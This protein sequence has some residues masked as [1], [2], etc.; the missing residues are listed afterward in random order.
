MSDPAAVTYF[1]PAKVNL[2]LSVRDLRS[3]GYHELHSLMV[4][5]SVGDDL[6]IAPADTL[7]LRVEGADL[8]IDEGN[9]VF[10]AARAYLDAAGVAG[11]AAITLHKRLPLAS[12]LGGGSS[13]AA[14][15]LMALARLYPAGVDLPGLALR[16]GADVPFF[17][18]G[19]AAVASGV[20]EVLSPTPV[21]RAALVLLNPGVEVSARDAYAWLDAEEAFTPAL[22]LEGIL[23]ALSNGRP[24]PYVNAL[25]GPVAARH[26]PIREALAALADAGLHSPLM[27]GSGSTCFALARDDAHAHDAAQVLAARHPGWWAQPAQVLG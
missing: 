11:G 23:A 10:R 8:P 17:L 1:A 15:T 3:D 24:V 9:L 4:P 22:D 19:R 26:A 20:G 2:G 7:T 6:Q 18:L 5:L 12:G 16:L 14:T 27:S 21:P 13:D 25:Q